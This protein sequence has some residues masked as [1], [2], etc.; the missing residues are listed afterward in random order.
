MIIRN[1]GVV[2]ALALLLLSTFALSP[3][4][5]AQMTD[6]APKMMPG[7]EAPSEGMGMMHH[8]LQDMSPWE[9]QR[10]Y[11]FRLVSEPEQPVAGEKTRLTLYIA[12]AAGNPLE[13]LMVYHERLVHFLVVSRNLEEFQH[14]HSEDAGLLTEDAVRAGRFTIPVVFASGG[15]YRVVVDFADSG[16]AVSQSFSI[17]VSGPRQRRTRWNFSSSRTV[18]DLNVQMER[19]PFQ[20][21]ERDIVN[22]VIELT[23]D[24]SPVTDLKPYLGAIAHL[25]IFQEGAARA[26]HT[27]GEEGPPGTPMS[28]GG[29]LGSRIYFGHVF[30]TDSRYRIF[31]QFDRGGVVHTIPFDVWVEEHT[32]RDD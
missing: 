11:R 14:L 12:D 32:E 17:R 18:E 21:K 5:M 28:M 9:V 19:Y 4:V 29:S 15:E 30:P 25:A 31:T 26:V 27:H 13:T 10:R 24:G 7:E 8:S 2:L 3:R 6:A 23:S 22:F 20:I 1:H 16:F